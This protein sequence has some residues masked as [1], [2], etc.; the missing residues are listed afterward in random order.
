MERLHPELLGLEVE[1]QENL[2][3]RCAAFRN[4]VKE[5][6]KQKRRQQFEE[7]VNEERRKKKEAVAEA[8]RSMAKVTIPATWTAPVESPFSDLGATLA[9]SIEEPLI[10]TEISVDGIPFLTVSGPSDSAEGQVIDMAMDGTDAGQVKDRPATTPITDMITDATGSGRVIDMAMDGT[11]AGQV[12]DRSVITPVTDMIMDATGSGRVTD[13]AMDGAESGQAVDLGTEKTSS[14]QATDLATDGAGTGQVT[15]MDGD[16]EGL[17]EELT[18]QDLS[19][20]KTVVPEV[21]T[22]QRTS[23]ESPSDSVVESTPHKASI[24]P[25]GA[26]AYRL[27]PLERKSKDGHLYDQWH[28][29]PRLFYLA[30]P[31]T[32]KD[33]YPSRMLHEARR[34]AMYEP[35]CRVAKTIPYGTS[36]IERMESVELK[37]GRVYQLSARWFAD[38]RASSQV[39]QSVQ[40]CLLEG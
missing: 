16:R 20:C 38:S 24:V 35:G 19:S 40:C 2:E 14:E 9:Y 39:A 27:I 17:E 25:A 12:K 29:D 36:H 1:K 15:E 21:V 34:Q 7:Q 5:E 30:A 23:L 3:K 33:E 31:S 18:T 13:M 4:E 8:R 37:D 22:I 11:D 6:E 10:Q 26:P 28:R 32:Y